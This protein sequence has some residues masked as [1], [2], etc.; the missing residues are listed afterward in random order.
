MRPAYKRMQDGYTKECDTCRFK[1]SKSFDT[2]CVVCKQFDRSK[3]DLFEEGNREEAKEML[4][5][6]KE[7]K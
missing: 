1:L 5:G 4:Y 3:V 7:D 6:K 2:L